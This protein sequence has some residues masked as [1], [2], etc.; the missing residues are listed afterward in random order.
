MPLADPLLRIEFEKIVSIRHPAPRKRRDE[1]VRGREHDDVA[2]VFDTGFSPAK[3]FVES[4]GRNAIEKM[5]EEY[6]PPSSA[7]AEIE[8]IVDDAAVEEHSG[9]TGR[10]LHPRHHQ[11]NRAAGE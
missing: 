11:R 9:Q 7:E 6:E 2:E 10:G 5:W 1:R 4:A 8:V 3:G